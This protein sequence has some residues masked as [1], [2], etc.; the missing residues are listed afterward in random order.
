MPS[1]TLA[2]AG[3]G[4]AWWLASR[5]DTPPPP[6]PT[7]AKVVEGYR[8]LV[9]GPVVRHTSLRDAWRTVVAAAPPGHSAAAHDLD[10]RYGSE[11]AS[12]GI[13]GSAADGRVSVSSGTARQ[14]DSDRS[15]SPTR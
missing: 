15:P 12:A 9:R 8:L 13:A 14:P 4:G 1:P 2:A 3:L 5:Q 6:V 11:A 10:L 7:A